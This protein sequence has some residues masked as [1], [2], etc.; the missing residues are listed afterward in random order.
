MKQFIFLFLILI[1]FYSCQKKCEVMETIIFDCECSF[2]DTNTFTVFITTVDQEN[3]Q[4]L[5]D[6]YCECYNDSDGDGI[7]DENELV[8]KNSNDL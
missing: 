1:F 5:E 3:C 8:N 4:I 2:I 6:C 7:C